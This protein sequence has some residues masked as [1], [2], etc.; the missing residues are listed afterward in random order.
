[1]G[2]TE[3]IPGARQGAEA[4]RHIDRSHCEAGCAL[5][6]SRLP[7][8]WDN[9]NDRPAG[10]SS[11]GTCRPDGCSSARAAQRRR[12]SDAAGDDRRHS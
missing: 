7:T 1:M 5:G 8:H 2:G 6:S 10:V 9:G 4:G 12:R 3:A 11:T